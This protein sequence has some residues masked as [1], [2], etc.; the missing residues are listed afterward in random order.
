MGTLGSIIVIM[1]VFA[2]ATNFIPK[3]KKSRPKINQ[4]QYFEDNYQRLVGNDQKQK[5]F[6]DRMRNEAHQEWIN[7]KKEEK[8]ATWRFYFQSILAIITFGIIGNSDDL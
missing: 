4:K 8:M 2:V 7:T 1:A 3:T 6:A 5:E